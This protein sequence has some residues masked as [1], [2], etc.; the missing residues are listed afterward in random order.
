MQGDDPKR[1]SPFFV[2]KGGVMRIRILAFA[3]AAS[4]TV[5]SLTSAPASSGAVEFRP[6]DIETKFPGGYAVGVI[7]VNK[8]GKLD[9]IGVSQRVPEL[10]WYENPTWER[11]VMTDGLAGIVNFA[12]ADIDGDG[13]PE[14]AFESGFAMSPASSEGI[15]WIVRHDGDPKGRWKVQ[16]IDK[17][18]TSHHIAWMDAD[19][20]GKKELVNAP[21][22]GARSA[23]PTYDQDK[24]PL[25]LYRQ[26]DWKRL[27]ITNDINGIIH[28][29][30]PIAWDGNKRDQLLVASFDGI[31]LWRASGR[32]ADLKWTSEL[33]SPGHNTDK[34]P[35]LGASD[36]AVGKQNG[37]RFLAAIEP[38]H[39]Q[40]IVVY[41]DRGGK[42]ERRV[43]FNGMTEGHEVAVADLNGDGR[44][45]IVAGDRNAKSPA[46]H[47]M[48]APADP[49]GEWTH[50]VLDEA[51]MAASGCVVADLNGDKRTD[52]VCIG[53]STANL[54]WYE[55]A[56]A[57]ATTSAGR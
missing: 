1:S 42:W 7:D 20:D 9:V 33:L 28:R 30:R 49:N 10:A 31:Q 27:T 54:K 34:A 46:V 40:E 23:A 38:W 22:V 29:V 26:N 35:K 12:A 3:A 11:H 47:V 13:I 16:Q 2:S 39:G 25:F 36:V 8:D 18:P 43:I 48:Y 55:N 21:L 17:F 37:K 6:H 4:L 51:K 32:G 14:V 50:Q 24:T 19:G 41:T 56:G 57:A 52:I 45:D 15:V 44:D 5:V 53:S